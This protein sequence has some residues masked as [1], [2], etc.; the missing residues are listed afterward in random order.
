MS[1]LARS[2]P[3]LTTG[4]ADLRP[5]PVIRVARAQSYLDLTSIV[6][7]LMSIGLIALA[8]IM[9]NGAN[10]FDLPSVFIVIL[11]TVFVTITSYTGRELRL[12]IPTIRGSFVRG[13]FNPGTVARE[14]LDLA[15]LSRKRGILSLGVYASEIRNN[16]DLYNATQ[17]VTDGLTAAEIDRMINQDMDITMDAY[18]KAAGM[19]RRASEIAPAMGLVGTLIGLVQM[20]VSLDNPAA[21]GP[22]MALALLTTFYGAVMGSVVLAPLAA[23]LERNAAEDNLIKSLIHAGMLAIIAQENP[24]K[25]EMELNSLLPPD[26]RISYFDL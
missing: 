5:D 10:F 1:D 21:I 14:I 25:L 12:A 19:L 24:R 15:V 6:G 9:G 2:E 7:I 3:S 17:M 22:A 16:P 18:R 11:G 20:L 4:T 13:A 8:I 26:L 23:K